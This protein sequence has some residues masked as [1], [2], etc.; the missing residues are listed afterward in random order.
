MKDCFTK[1]VSNRSFWNNYPCS[2]N[3]KAFNQSSLLLFSIYMYYKLAVTKLSKELFSETLSHINKF[4][5]FYIAA[6]QC[7]YSYCIL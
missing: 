1:H 7:R 5:S 2:G 4:N 6:F 3:S